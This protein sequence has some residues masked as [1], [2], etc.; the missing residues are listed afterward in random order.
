MFLSVFALVGSQLV[1]VDV[2]HARARPGYPLLSLNPTFTSHLISYPTAHFIDDTVQMVVTDPT[3]AYDADN[4]TKAILVNEKRAITH[5]YELT[6]FDTAVLQSPVTEVDILITFSWGGGIGKNP[7]TL[8]IAYDPGTGAYTDLESATTS[9][10]ALKTYTW[11]DKTVTTFGSFKIKFEITCVSEADG[12]PVDV[13]EVWVAQTIDPTTSYP[14]PP[15]SYDSFIKGASFDVNVRVSNISGTDWPAG[16]G[17]YE[18]E[19]WYNTTVLTCTGV[20]YILTWFESYTEWFKEIS[21]PSGKVALVVSLAYSPSSPIYG[22]GDVLTLHFKVDQKGASALYLNETELG[23]WEIPATPIPHEKYDG[24]YSYRPFDPS[25]APAAGFTFSPSSPL[26]DEAINF[27]ASTSYESSPST[28]TL[29]GISVSNPTHAYD[30]N[31]N[32]YANFTRNADGY[33]ELN[34]FS[35]PTIP[36]GFSI[37]RVDLHIKFEADLSWAGTD[38]DLYRVYYLVDPS[39]TETDLVPWT[40]AATALANHTYWDLSEP[41]DQVWTATDVGNVKLRFGTDVRGTAEDL[42]VNVYEAWLEVQMGG[43]YAL[44]PWAFPYPYGEGRG[45]LYSYTWDFN[46]TPAHITTVYS[47]PTIVHTY[48]TA[49]TYTVNLTVTDRYGLTSYYTYDV[50]VTEAV[51]EFPLIAPL[52]VA[53]PIV[54]LYVWWRSRRKINTIRKYGK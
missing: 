5:Y 7:D 3:Y 53:L 14:T 18:F 30:W 10:Y 46:E 6:S 39:A 42:D 48:S 24:H 51:P 52:Y 19:L 28:H 20:T 45:W 32:T 43:S 34:G 31:F 2:A 13:Y 44:S 17:G 4:T 8:L 27:N 41:Y 12:I 26:V 33:F 36:S 29:S 37:F 11:K 38:Q 54:I 47:D 25:T 1:L 40:Y 23:T 16:L 22:S 9:A 35:S 50:T 49:D 15:T 21:D